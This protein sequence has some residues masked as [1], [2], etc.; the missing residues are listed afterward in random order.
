MSKD[1]L[2]AYGGTINKETGKIENQHWLSYTLLPENIPLDTIIANK[3]NL[4]TSISY[5]RVIYP[6]KATIDKWLENNLDL[7]EVKPNNKPLID[8]TNP[9]YNINIGFLNRN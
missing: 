1:F 7:E 9:I 5:R 6:N 8:V 2:I 4:D 3:Q